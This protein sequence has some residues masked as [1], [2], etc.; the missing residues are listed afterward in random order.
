MQ[1]LRPMSCAV[2]MAMIKRVDEKSRGPQMLED[3]EDQ[4]IMKSLEHACHD[5]FALEMCR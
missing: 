3:L 2:D 4:L 1:K 5:R